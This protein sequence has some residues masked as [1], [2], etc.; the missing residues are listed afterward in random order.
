MNSQPV[1]T[2]IGL[3]TP[4]GATPAATWDALLAGRYITDHAL[5]EN[6]SAGQEPRT[7]VLARSVARQAIADAG[8][9]QEQLSDEALVVGSSEGPVERWLP[10]TGPFAPE[11]AFGLADVAASL[12]FCGGPRTTIS[13]AC[14]SGLAALGQAAMW[15]RGGQARRVLVVAVES[16]VH[17]LFIGSFARLGVVARPEIGCRPFDIARRGFLLSEAAA[18][19]CVEFASSGYVRIERVA[20]GG[21]ATHLTAMDPQGRTLR[22][23]LKR[24]LAGQSV[25][26][27]HAHGTGTQANDAVEL[28]AIEAMVAGVET[29]ASSKTPHVH[30]GLLPVVYSHKAAL[31]HSLGASGLVGVTLDCLMHRHALIPP[32]VRTM[33]P[34]PTQQVCFA[35]NDAALRRTV[36]RSIVVAAGFGGATATAALVSAE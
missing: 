2:G 13:A 17:P 23:L 16:S 33:H 21:D 31:G 3:I 20:L 15:L 36:Q 6:L 14:A 10:G 22:A 7:H 30:A 27:I 34:L 4:L 1:I 11:A 28:A 35:P 26:L 8:W 18:A 29:S 5:V 19:V 12:G 9:N 32:L 25:D 24:V